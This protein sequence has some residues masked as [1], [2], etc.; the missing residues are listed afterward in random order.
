MQ[1]DWAEIACEVPSDMVDVLADFL[2]E[3]TGNGV[4]IDNLHLD[5]FSLDTLA[6]SPTKI[7]RGYLP[8]D[9]SLEELSIRVEQFLAEVGPGFPGFVYAKPVVNVVRNEDW[10]NNW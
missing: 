3:L 7:V 2:V 1:N 9:D 10:A 8:L 5:T 6:D 4:G